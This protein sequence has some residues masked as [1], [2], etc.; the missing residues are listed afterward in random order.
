MTL[1]KSAFH[2]GVLCVYR[3]EMS[4]V[5]SGCRRLGWEVLGSRPWCVWWWWGG[6]VRQ[7]C[8]TDV[9]SGLGGIFVLLL[10]ISWSWRCS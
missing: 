7:T 9:Q 2:S 6:D 5:S 4:R 1:R 8:W 3:W 10:L